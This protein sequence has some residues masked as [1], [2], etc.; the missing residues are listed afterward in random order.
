MYAAD[1][2]KEG[3]HLAPAW[4]GSTHRGLS[5]AIWQIDSADKATVQARG[6]WA[7]DSHLGPHDR[8]MTGCGSLLWLQGEIQ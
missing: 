8:F 3:S 4:Q 6:R 2:M 7:H 5:G 1:A